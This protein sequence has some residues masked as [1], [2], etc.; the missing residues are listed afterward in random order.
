M[1]ELKEPVVLLLTGEGKGKTTSGV[2]QVVR[3]AG[4]GYK[5]A[6]L[7]FMKGVKVGEDFALERLGV[8]VFF[9]G[10]GH[11][12]D[13]YKPEEEDKATIRKFWEEMKPKLPEYDVV[14]LDE[15]NLAVFS[16]IIAA[17]EI[18]PLLKKTPP[19]LLILIGRR[20][21]PELVELASVASE[22]RLIKHHYPKVSAMRGLEA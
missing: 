17:E 14:L 10:P 11:F 22:V 15:F 12:M 3:A 4:R 8:D 7:H 6:V 18:K 13:V 9:S 19:Y 16:R 1:E 20:A 5:C 2:G 21:P